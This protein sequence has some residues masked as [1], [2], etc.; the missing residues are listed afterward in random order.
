MSFGVYA[1]GKLLE[2]ASVV[3][4]ALTSNTNFANVDRAL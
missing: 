1:D 2:F 4:S 3:I